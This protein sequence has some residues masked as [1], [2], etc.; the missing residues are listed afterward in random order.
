MLISICVVTFKRPQGLRLLLK[1]L[2]ELAFREIECP[3]IEVIV[4]DNDTDK[5][6]EE[7]CAEIKPKFRWTLKAGVETRR[8][9]T[10][11]RNKSI[12]M[13]SEDADY[14]AILDDDEIP[15]SSWLE[16]LLL[17]QQKYDSGIVTG[18]VI[19]HFNDNRVPNWIIKGQFF[20]PPRYKTGEQRTVAFTNNVM[21]KAEILRKLTPVFD[22]RFAI[23]GGSDSHLF[24]NL[25]KAGHK[26]T[27]ADEAVVYDVISASRTNLKWI[28]L[29][30]YREWS[31]YS[32]HEKELYPS[33]S[34]QSVRVLKGLALIVIGIL[35]LIP[36]LLTE[37]ATV[38]TSLLYISRGV[39]TL[40]GLLGLSYQEYKSI[41]NYILEG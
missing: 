3:E 21:V 26:I 32:A 41:T 12:S 16:A 38:V 9:I 13:V 24:L 15:E 40:G 18:P 29:R 14:I 23:S 11:A 34:I 31:N 37:K 2:N 39:G 25:H 30:G 28:L 1:G 27:W 8:G 22:N 19:P 35:Y 33:F 4:V 7:I 5:L 17:V 10:Y 20:E 36:A 6:A